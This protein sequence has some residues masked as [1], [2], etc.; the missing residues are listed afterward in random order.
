MAGSLHTTIERVWAELEERWLTKSYSRFF[1]LF[2]SSMNSTLSQ[3]L[4][5]SPEY[6]WVPVEQQATPDSHSGCDP[7]S[8]VLSSQ[9]P[10]TI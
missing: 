6:F 4:P 8:V 9:A 7:L 3:I 10:R 5:S 1:A 2:S